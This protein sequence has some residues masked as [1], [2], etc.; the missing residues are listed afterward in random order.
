MK[1]LILCDKAT[2]DEIITSLNHLPNV[3]SFK[4]IQHQASVAE[5]DMHTFL[6]EHGSYQ[7]MNSDQLLEQIGGWLDSHPAIA[8]LMMAELEERPSE[9]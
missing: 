4:V 7:G 8:D 1:H 5:T 2:K 3:H 9:D 6:T